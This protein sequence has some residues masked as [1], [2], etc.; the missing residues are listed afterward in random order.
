[1]GETRKLKT[2]CAHGFNACGKQQ[3][4]DKSETRKG[5]HR[6]TTVPLPEPLYVNYWGK[7]FFL[8]YKNLIAVPAFLGSEI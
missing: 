1:M 7:F 2:G 3:G 6:W 5:S 4:P 8:G